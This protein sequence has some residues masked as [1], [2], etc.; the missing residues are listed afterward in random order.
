[1]A[2]FATVTPQNRIQL[3]NTSA[4]PLIVPIGVG[5]GTPPTSGGATF[6]IFRIA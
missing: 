6:I 2:I 3:K 4:F 5:G 1:M